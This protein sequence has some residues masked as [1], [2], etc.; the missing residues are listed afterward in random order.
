MW[1]YCKSGISSRRAII[2]MKKIGKY[3]VSNL[4]GGISSWLSENL[5]VVKNK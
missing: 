4:E 5:P 2:E 1:F 3:K